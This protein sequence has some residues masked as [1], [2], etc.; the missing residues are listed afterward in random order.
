MENQFLREK[1]GDGVHFYQV[2]DPKFKHNRITVNLIL[3]L[4][5]ESV[6]VNAVL[7]FLLR[8]GC[9]SCPDFTKLNQ[10]LCELYGA[11]LS[12]DVSKFGAYQVLEL[13]IY[14]IDD[15]FT[16]GGETMAAECAGL[17]TDVLLAPNFGA[18]GLFPETDVETERQQLMDTIEGQINDKRVYALSRCKALMCE[19]EPLAIEKYGYIDD[20]KKIT[21]ESAAAA[22]EK[23]IETAQVEISFVGC[24]NPATAKKIFTDAFAKV[25][26]SPARMEKYVTRPQADQ[27]KETKEE[28]DVAQSKLVLG[29]RTGAIR[30][31]ETFGAMRMMVALFGGT[32]NSRLFTYVREKLS[33]CYYCAAR[34]DR[35]TGLMMVDSG[36][37]KVNKQKAQDEILNQLGVMQ[38]GE[39][40]DDELTAT[41]LL[42]QN[43]LRS[44]TDS[45]GATEEWYLTQVM[46]GGSSSP[47]DEIALIDT[48]TREAIIKAANQV[49]LDTVYFLTGKGD[50]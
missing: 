37:E 50:A 33:L 31:Q 39:F 26:R 22:Y 44:V 12:C 46:D 18:D 21:P 3:P 41:K 29:F 20:A 2:T 49:T 36:V 9:K 48:V 16:L 13:S 35:L 6:T 10:K 28:L 23:A 17:L 47:A 45:L 32:P 4:C 27:P 19:G 43:A 30:D 11:S 15:R 24:G 25:R 5:R 38:R 7:P 40:T 42:L 1:I 8:K 14:G 34:F